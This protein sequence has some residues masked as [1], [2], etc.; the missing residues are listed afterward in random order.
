[1]AT[2]FINRKEAAEYIGVTEGTLANWDCTKRYEIPKYK[3][4]RL[5]K[6]RKADLDKWLETRKVC[7]IEND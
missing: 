5:V 4:G 6:Y 1:M 2:N 7:C 3:I